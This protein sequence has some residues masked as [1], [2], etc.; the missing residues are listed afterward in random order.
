MYESELLLDQVTDTKKRKR[1]PSAAAIAAASSALEPVTPS[2][3]V[4]GARHDLYG[5]RLPHNDPQTGADMAAALSAA[6]SLAAFS[7]SPIRKT[8]PARASA[9][10]R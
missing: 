10:I 8:T 1:T 6:N 9:T 7:A 5:M 4:R 3:G 2:G